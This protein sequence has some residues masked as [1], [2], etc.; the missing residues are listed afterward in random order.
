MRV[1]I[2]KQSKIKNRWFSQPLSNYSDLMPFFSFFQKEIKPEFP[3]PTVLQIFEFIKPAFETLFVQHECVVMMLIYVERLIIEGGVQLSSLNWRPIIYTG[4]LLASK[5]WEDISVLNI[6]FVGMYPF[7]TI[8]SMNLLE[9]NFASALNWKL[10]ISPEQYSNYYFRLKQ[11]ISP[12]N[13]HFKRR[14]NRTKSYTS[15]A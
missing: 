8:R 9:A 3:V 6:D 1:N 7:Y 13:E 5:I 14:G 12:I 2:W 15:V 10:F 11:M 4:L